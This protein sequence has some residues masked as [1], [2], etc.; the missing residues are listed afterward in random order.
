MFMVSGSLA[1]VVNDGLVRLAVD[2]GLDV[3]Q[4]LFLRGCG[5]VVILVAIRRGR[6]DRL[7]RRHLSGPL[8]V[9]VGAEVVVAAAFFT[10]IAHV[11]FATAHTILMAAPFAVTVVAARLGERVTRG[12]YVPVA[13]GFVGVL[14]VVRPTPDGFSPWSLLIV[15]AATALVVRDVATKRIERHT[16]PWTIA[17]LTAAALTTLTGIL[18]A[19]TGWGSITARSALVLAL[20]CGLLVAAYLLLIE[21]VRIAELSVSA[22]LRYTTVVGAVLVGLVFFGEVPDGPTMLGCSLIVVAGATAARADANEM[23]NQLEDT[24]G[25]AAQDSSISPPLVR[26]KPQASR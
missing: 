26:R 1:A 24:F 16:S 9:R 15:A 11:E 12:R 2:D 25:P 23:A 19:V 13:V 22:P 14:A 17:L 5:M 8:L 7:D 21:A 6:A 3:Y 10:A 18:S 4:A 20:A